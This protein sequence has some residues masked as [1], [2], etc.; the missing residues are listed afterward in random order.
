MSSA[1]RCRRPARLMRP[2]LCRRS[3]PRLMTSHHVRRID[4]RFPARRPACHLICRGR[5]RPC[6]RAQRPCGRAG[7]CADAATCWFRPKRRRRAAHWRIRRLPVWN[8]GPVTER[9][10]ARRPRSRPTP[11]PAAP[12]RLDR[13]LPRLLSFSAAPPSRAAAGSFISFVGVR[14]AASS[15]ITK[16]VG[17]A[18]DMAVCL[19]EVCGRRVHAAS[20]GDLALRAGVERRQTAGPCAA[21]GGGRR[22]APVGG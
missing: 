7:A 16:P 21:R 17:E 10:Q 15:A 2:N 20:S 3:M 18:F 9:R 5:A 4:P 8:P 13:G 12:T 11:R 19:A 1:R 22:R 6:R 14:L